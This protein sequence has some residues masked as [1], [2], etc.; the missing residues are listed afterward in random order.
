MVITASNLSK[1]YPRASI[2]RAEYWR[3][4]F[5]NSP[6]PKA[7]DGV[8]FST[9]GG[10]VTGL[11]G[12]NGAGKS[13]LLK[14]LA[15]LLPPDEGSL[16]IGGLDSAADGPRIRAIAALA[17]A[18]PR[19]FYMRLSAKE[20]LEFFGALYG[21]SKEQTAG[22]AGAFFGILDIARSDYE[23]RFD[24]LSAGAMQK[25]SLVRTLMRDSEILLLDESA[26]D[27][28]FKSAAAFRGL[29]KR[30]AAGGRTVIYASHNLQELAGISDKTLVLKNGKLAA[31]IPGTELRKADALG[32][33]ALEKMFTEILNHDA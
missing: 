12:P 8:T 10:M 7:V 11:A 14:L 24:R 18:K 6:P 16:K 4:Q 29:V 1:S 31:E 17:E 21:F 3:P 27:L 19:S 13:T 15:G 2:L 9:Q 30:L 32:R 22:R 5:K 28:D 20:N 33:E 26:K 23:K 25:F